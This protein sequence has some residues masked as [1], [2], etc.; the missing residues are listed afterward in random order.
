MWDSYWN[1][2]IFLKFKFVSFSENAYQY[3]KVN[4]KWKL[5][6]NLFIFREKEQQLK[7]MYLF[8]KF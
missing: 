6:K 8:L 3:V 4:T 5:S 2:T 1:K 7:Y